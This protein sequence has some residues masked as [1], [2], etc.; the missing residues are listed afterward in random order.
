MNLMKSY[1]N[2]PSRLKQEVKLSQ[3][4]VKVN[5]QISKWEENIK[6]AKNMLK[7]IQRIK[8]KVSGLK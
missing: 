4:E 3:T 5:I 8:Q 6:Q 1:W 7:L 2:P